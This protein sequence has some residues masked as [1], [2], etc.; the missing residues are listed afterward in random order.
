MRE[1]NLEK[2]I[3]LF[4]AVLLVVRLVDSDTYSNGSIF[5]GIFDFLVV[6]LDVMVFYLLIIQ[7]FDFRKQ[8]EVTLEESEDLK[9]AILDFSVYELN[10]SD[11]HIE[12]INIGKSSATE[13]KGKLSDSN[14]NS[15][16]IT[17]YSKDPYH[18]FGMIKNLTKSILIP[19][20]ALFYYVHGAKKNNSYVLQLEF[21]DKTGMNNIEYNFRI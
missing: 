7:I 18:Q 20:K 12:V 2:V 17:V 3:L 14:G 4:L 21:N 9:K 15:Y 1:K 11:L 10:Q 16:K 19:E 6:F 13:I 5:T 8:L